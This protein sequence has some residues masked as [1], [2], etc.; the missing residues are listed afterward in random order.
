MLR[1]KE[2][3]QEK[4]Q[5]MRQ[6]AIALGIP[7]T[8]YISYEK[9]DREPNS[10]ML[11]ALAEYFNC[12]IDYLVGRSNE[13]ISDEVLDQVN[14]LDNDLLVFH[15]NI[16][17][18]KKAQ[19]ERY[20]KLTSSQQF[21]NEQPLDFLTSDEMSQ[22]KKYRTLDEYGKKIMNS[23]LN[24]EYDRC[25]HMEEQST[26]ELPI[27]LISASAGTGQWLGDDEYTERIRVADTAEARKAN[28]VIEVNGNSMLPSYKDGDK[29]LVRLQ[30]DINIG[31]IGIFVV[32][33]SAYIKEKGKNELVSLNPEFDNIAINEYDRIDCVGKVLGIA[34]V[35][36]YSI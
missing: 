11:I 12:S 23:V 25:T 17:D 32:N 26:I 35:I 14:L 30:R 36:D 33:G 10:E 3:R 27:Q 28:L 21:Y 15:G 7:Y 34:D 24:I 19:K 29:V 2:L 20:S 16:H 6:T 5:N 1:L 9:G 18:A 13:R 4:K 31:E 8:T 22:I